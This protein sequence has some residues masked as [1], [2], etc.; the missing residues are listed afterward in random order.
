MQARAVVSAQTPISGAL[1]LSRE[2][3][4]EDIGLDTQDVRGSVQVD[5]E[6]DSEE[7]SSADVMVV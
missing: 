5:S 3:A 1:G 6:A 2:A 7:R 4:R